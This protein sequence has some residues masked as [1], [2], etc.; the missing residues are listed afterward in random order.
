MNI[1]MLCR[2]WKDIFGSG[3]WASTKYN[4]IAKIFDPISIVLYILMGIIGA[5]GAIYAVYLGIQLA[6]AD[7]QSK[8]DEAKK[9]LITVLIAIGVTI[10]LVLFFNLLLPEIVN[11]LISV[12]ESGGDK[13]TPG[14]NTPAKLTFMVNAIKS[15]IIK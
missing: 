8:R 4:W 2:T 14:N 12:P 9:H 7:E 5:A 6:K 15:I 3:I 10:V 11:A 13:P 1:S